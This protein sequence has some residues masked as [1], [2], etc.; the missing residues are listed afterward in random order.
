MKPALNMSPMSEDRCPVCETKLDAESPTTMVLSTPRGNQLWQRCPECQSFFAA[1]RDDLE[2]EVQHTRTRPWGMVESGTALN[3]YKGLMFEAILRVLRVSASPGSMLLDVGC[4]YGGFLQR[5]RREGYQVRGIDIVPEA[6]EYVRSQGIAC[7]CVKSV[8]DLDIPGN[9][10]GI[11]SV[12]DCNYY[13]P[14]QKEELRVF[15]SRLRPGGILVMRV[16]D[17]SWAIKIGFWLR[18]WFPT[19]GQR[20]C[21]K[22]VYD[23]RVSIPIRSLLR[24]VQQEG[25][26]I[27]YT[28]L[29]NAMPS[30][31]SSIKVKIAYAIGHFA[32][33]VAGYF[34]APG[35]VFL[36][37]KRTP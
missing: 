23:H 9:S 36:A 16:V 4:S 37:R 31:Y 11:I 12:L 24:V 32:W 19:I 33:W 7:D 27:V 6:V 10:Q 25:F 3:D 26:E 35:C 18:R 2:Q 21:E 17:T 8:G 14:S 1:E 29:C 15:Y 13:W 30:R 28:S 20:L 22:A 34:V 5:A